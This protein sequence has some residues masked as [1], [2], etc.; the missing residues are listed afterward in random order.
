MDSGLLAENEI[1][2]IDELEFRRTSSNDINTIL[3]MEN[4]HANAD[5][6]RQW[7]EQKHLDAIIDRDIEHVVVESADDKRI[8][9]YIILIG[10]E[11]ADLGLEFKRIL[12]NEKGKGYGRISVRFIK[13]YAFDRLGFHRLWLEVVEYNER[14]FKLYE[15]EGFLIE[16][17]HR[18]SIRKGDRFYNLIVMSILSKEYYS[19]S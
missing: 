9:G 16:G 12:I 17:N 7:S 8:V 6:I 14:A 15:S 2:K 1:V 5:F 10:L 3:E 19:R 4:D 13:Q 18:E 11:N